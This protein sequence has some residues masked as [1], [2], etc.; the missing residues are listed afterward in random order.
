MIFW[1]IFFLTAILSSSPFLFQVWLLLKLKLWLSI[2]GSQAKQAPLARSNVGTQGSSAPPKKV[3]DI[4]EPQTCRNRGCGKTFKEK[5]NHETACCYHPGPAIF[6]DRLRGVCFAASYSSVCYSID[7]F[8]DHPYIFFLFAYDM[9]VEVLWYPCKGVWWI[10]EHSTLFQGMAQCWSSV[11]SFARW[12]TP[13]LFLVFENF[14]LTIY[15]P[16]WLFH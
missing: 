5:D 16:I 13:L 8:N 1:Y 2:L 15:F 6:H 14:V 11:L 7:S 3:I 12:S 4:N 9:A 10:Y